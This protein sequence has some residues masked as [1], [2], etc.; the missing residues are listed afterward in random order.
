[1][2]Y[3]NRYSGFYGTDL[4][5]R[6]DRD[7]VRTVVVTGVLSHV[8]V[9]TTARDAFARD[10]DVVVVRDAVAGVDARLHRAALQNLAE[11]VGAVV[12]ADEVYPAIAPHAGSANP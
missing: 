8:C 4:A 11:T 9:D 10:L 7:R 2:I 3:K 5:E 6:L 1:M 12:P